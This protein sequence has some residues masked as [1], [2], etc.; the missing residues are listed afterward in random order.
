VLGEG[1]A[2]YQLFPRESPYNAC[3]LILDPL[4]QVK[5]AD[6][7]LFSLLEWGGFGGSLL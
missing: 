6:L 7:L 3:Y 1:E 4:R 2:G 5:T